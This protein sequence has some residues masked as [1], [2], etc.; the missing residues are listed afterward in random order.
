MTRPNR[1][2]SVQSLAQT[3]ISSVV[4]LGHTQS[5]LGELTKHVIVSIGTARD[6]QQ[7]VRE[8]LT[9][10]IACGTSIDAPVTRAELEEYLLEEGG[11]WR[12]KTLD[13]HRQ[14][15]S[16]VFTVTLP[17][18]DAEIPTFTRGRA[19]LQ[20]EMEEVALRQDAHNALGTRIAFHSGLRAIELIE[21]RGAHQLAPQPDRPWRSDLFLGLSDGAIYR[22]TGKGGLARSVW[23]PRGLHEQ[24]QSRRL[25]TPVA[26]MD[27]KARRT[28]V[29]D[30]G[31]GHSLSQSFSHL[32][33]RALGFSE[34]L[35]GLRHAYAQRRIGTLLS[36]EI[37]PLHCLEI[38]SQE[39]GHLRPE[40]SLAYTSRRKDAEKR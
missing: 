14:A 3:L 8:F 16:L 25:E 31:G 12:Q 32:S 28:R 18:F 4:A 17:M 23:I 39:L 21:L 29:F 38:V 37:D 13:Q 20:E 22:V 1:K 2:P 7:C 5:A 27:R 9:W 33:K 19:Y 26:V 11:R 30:L 15:L 36:L 34:G 40:I 35:H 6:F 24:L 10:R